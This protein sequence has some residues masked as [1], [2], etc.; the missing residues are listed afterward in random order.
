MPRLADRRA[1]PHMAV[2]DP[3]TPDVCRICH[4]PTGTRNDV[5]LDRPPEVDPAI[6]AAE[7]RRIGDHE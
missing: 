3:D 7:H 6:T 1:R 2:E 5:H 4:L